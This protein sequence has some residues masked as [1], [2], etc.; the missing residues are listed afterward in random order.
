V[1]TLLKPDYNQRTDEQLHVL[2]LYQLCDLAG[3]VLPPNYEIPNHFLQ[4]NLQHKKEPI[5][6]K[7]R[8][9]CPQ[10]VNNNKK[11]SKVEEEESSLVD[12]KNFQFVNE[13]TLQH[14][15][16][17][18]M[19]AFTRFLN[20]DTDQLIPTNLWNDPKKLSATGETM[21]H[22]KNEE[23]PLFRQIQD[24]SSIKKEELVTDEKPSVVGGTEAT[25][26]SNQT[27]I[28]QDM[29][30]VAI[31]LGHGS[32]LIECAKKELHA[33][34]ALRNPSRSK[35]TRLS[36]VF[37]QHKKLNRQ[38]HGY[39]ENAEKDRQRK[40]SKQTYD[41]MK[42]LED[43][44][45]DSNSGVDSPVKLP[46]AA[47]SNPQIHLEANLKVNVVNQTNLDVVDSSVNLT[48]AAA[49]NLTDVKSHNQSGM[50][51]QGSISK[52]SIDNIISQTGRSSSPQLDYVI[53]NAMEN[54]FSLATSIGES[55]LSH[56][57]Q[58]QAGF[59]PTQESTK[60]SQEKCI[61]VG[62]APQ[63][64]IPTFLLGHT[65]P[66]AD[67]ST[68]VP[69]N[70]FHSV[71]SGVEPSLNTRSVIRHSNPDLSQL[72]PQESNRG[73]NSTNLELSNMSSFTEGRSQNNTQQGLHEQQPWV[74]GDVSAGVTQPTYTKPHTLLDQHN[75]I[76]KNFSCGVTSPQATFLSPVN[77]LPE[78]LVRAVQGKNVLPSPINEYI[79]PNHRHPFYRNLQSQP[80]PPPPHYNSLLSPPPPNYS[81]QRHYN[82]TAKDD[83]SSS[84]H[85][86]QQQHQQQYPHNLLD[87]HANMFMRNHHPNH[88]NN[89]H[90]QRHQEHQFTNN[91]STTNA[92]L[93]P[94]HPSLMLSM[95]TK[96]VNPWSHLSNHF[97]G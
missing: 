10:A 48:T 5:E 65:P 50:S 30:G 95:H 45:Q 17:D 74:N 64:P 62:K 39:H 57:I 58:P 46:T 23:V 27:I 9:V 49:D 86:H 56:S 96:G 88:N 71:Y 13:K 29:G 94:M 12:D 51:K 73:N 26:L 24:M 76:M 67:L 61:P 53:G 8:Y 80:Q 79:N 18:S 75:E 19:K 14:V 37:Y 41:D 77:P 25:P 89:H 87:M 7:G 6:G 55:I 93:T 72:N 82:A 31:A 15:F 28:T 97:Q 3:N 33:T 1:C 2:P 20:G 83:V 22:I 43:S 32:F 63:Q 84:H 90:N 91:D 4:S 16:N 42:L 35:P 52:F 92:R 66:T 21:V 44:N 69:T 60:L 59:Q 38:Q 78:D 47:N 34:T 40:V 54:S 70:D 81:Y 85:H 36:M 11:A 68:T